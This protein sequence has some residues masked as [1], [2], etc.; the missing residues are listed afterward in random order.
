MNEIFIKANKIQFI[1]VLISIPIVLFFIFILWLRWD[2]V[3]YQSLKEIKVFLLCFKSKKLNAFLAFLVP[4]LIIMIGIII[5]E[6]I[7]GAFM[8]FF[9]KNNWK[10]VKFGIVKKHFM[11]Y[12]NCIEPLKSIQMLIVALAPFIIL[13]LIPSLYGILYGNLFFLFIGFSMTLG[14]VGDFIYTYLIFK[15]GL[16]QLILDHENE[17]GF[18]IV[19]QI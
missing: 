1:G 13:G 14:A 2:T 4:N 11:P 3:F 18:K 17:V 15:V 8:A 12:A 10:S 16:N 19:E 5:H 7:H 9:S 6:L